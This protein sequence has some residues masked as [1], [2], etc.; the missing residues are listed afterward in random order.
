MNLKHEVRTS[1]TSSDVK[2]IDTN[3]TYK[4]Q[5]LNTS[6]FMTCSKSKHFDKK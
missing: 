3:F 5:P 4:Y 6:N 2:K 1:V